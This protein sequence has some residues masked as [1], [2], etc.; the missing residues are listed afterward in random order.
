VTGA[1]ALALLLLWL[2]REG[3]SGTAPLVMAVIALLGIPELW[4]SAIYF[5]STIL[6]MPLLAGAILLARGRGQVLAPL[7]A[8]IL[9]GLAVMTRLDFIL[10]CPLLAMAAWPRG[11]GL[12]RPILLAVGVV[13]TLLAGFAIGLLDLAEIMRIQ[14]IASAE[15]RDKAHV[16][17]WDM[18]MKLGVASISLSPVGWLLL[19]ASTPLVM[20]EAWRERNWRALLWILALLPA[21]YP[22]FNILSPKYILPLAPFLL[23]LFQKGLQLGWAKL[24]ARLQRPALGMILAIGSIPIVLSVSL[25]GHAPFLGVGLQPSRPVGTHDGK[26]GYGG[27]VWQMAA[28][29]DVKKDDHGAR[30]GQFIHDFIDGSRENIL[31]LGGENYFDQGGVAWRGGQ[32][33]L[34]RRGIQAQLIGPHMLRFDL[35]NGRWLI[36]SRSLPVALPKQP[37][38]LIDWR[39]ANDDLS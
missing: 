7:V 15:I 2:W 32:L 33:T 17:G 14:A 6:A 18:R 34:A 13:V 28:I 36:L 31:F 3:R 16:P 20:L 1:S 8:G 23:L 5:N 26:R 22:L 11:A 25:F 21:L 10:I 37:Y 35:G 4:L 9:A 24:G 27:Y 30:A 12:T 38:R 29:D 39:T 19:A